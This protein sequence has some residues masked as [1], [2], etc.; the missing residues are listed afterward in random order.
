MPAK[1]ELAFPVTEPLCYFTKEVLF[2]MTDMNANTANVRA[3][4]NVF[5]AAALFLI[6]MPGVFGLVSS[7][8][9][10]EQLVIY[11]YDSFASSGPA[12]YVAA[13]FKKKHPDV[14]VV[15]VALGDAGEALAKLAAELETG[16]SSADVF[17]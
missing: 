10:A 16:G 2:F 3:M 15:F 1:E 6:V 8:A 5:R 17:V 11:T 4:T 13:E 12:D 14:D 7:S 9:R